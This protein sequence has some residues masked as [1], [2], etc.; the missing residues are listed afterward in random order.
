MGQP[1]GRDSP[2][3]AFELP[4]IEADHAERLWRAASGVAHWPNLV[5]KKVRPGEEYEPGHF[6]A[7]S[8]PDS[9]LMVEVMRAAYDMTLYAGGKY[10][11]WSDAPM[12]A[13]AGNARRWL[14]DQITLRED[15]DQEVMDRLRRTDD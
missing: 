8:L 3:V 1:A 5:L 7:E 10:I 6:R 9:D 12:E 2:R 13:L 4:C 15:F 11:L 14:A